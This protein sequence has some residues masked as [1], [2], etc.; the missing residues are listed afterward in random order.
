[1]TS[2]LQE[3]AGLIRRETGIAIDKSQYPALA[4]ALRRVSPEMDAQQ[5]ITETGA[6]GGKHSLLARLVDEVTIKETYFLRETR[7][8]EALD[9]A[10][11]L[12]AAR[13]HGAAEARVWVAACATGEEAYTLA[14]LACEAFGG[15]RPP[16]SILATDVSGAAI[17]AAARGRY[18]ERA[19]RNVSLEA[20]ERYFLAEDQVHAVGETL[21]S[22]VRFRRHNLTSDP[23]PPSGEVPFDLIACRNVL[24]YFDPQ[25]VDRVIAGLESALRPGGQIV[26]GSA[27]RLAGSAARTGS[28]GPARERRASGS[29]PDPQ[30]RRKTLGVQRGRGQRSE[31]SVPQEPAQAKSAEQPGPIP[32]E[33]G[34]RLEDALAA[35]D[36][37]ELDAAIAVTDRLLS[38]DP[39]NP[40]AYFV[41]GLA[42]LGAGRAREAVAS[43]RRAIYVDPTFALAAF[44]LGRAQDSL[45][46][47]GAAVRA[48]SQAL[49]VLDPADERHAAILGQVDVGDIATAC[50]ARLQG[51]DAGEP[52]PR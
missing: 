15:L 17:D 21:H 11:I 12:E 24:I 32:P 45:G 44:E 14:I 35:A 20:R 19:M 46:D 22:M 28:A 26:L 38:G 34:R 49:R 4:A 3:V 2:Q 29:E 1:M 23:F 33:G 42:E 37:G 18:R 36:R 52:G 50:R 41:R 39:L 31:R 8:L 43:F 5:F 40:D 10:A 25:T 27:D 9:W 16:A 30:K 51:A 7:E 6:P 48:Y 13:A 47:D